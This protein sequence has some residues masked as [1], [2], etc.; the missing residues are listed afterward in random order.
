MITDMVRTRPRE[1]MARILESIS[2]GRPLVGDNIEMY[3]ATMAS[4]S[5]IRYFKILGGKL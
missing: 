3:R 1:T 5:E 4:R 2:S